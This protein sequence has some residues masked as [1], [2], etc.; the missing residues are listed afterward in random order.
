MTVIKNTPALLS[1]LAAFAMCCVSSCSD[2][3][4]E[5]PVEQ[6]EDIFIN[7]LYAAG[8][9]WIELYN[10]GESTKDISGYFI[11]D[12]AAN[13]SQLP[14][15]TT[16]PAKGFLILTCDDTGTGLHTNFRLTSEGESVYL[17]TADGKLIDKVDFPPLNDGQSYGRYPDGAANLRISGN[18]SQG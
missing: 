6:N 9:D 11:Y 13:K 16:I 4:N 1:I 5:E 14:T 12:D 3:G 17:G 8:D 2:D 18:T 7:E 15:N 10:A